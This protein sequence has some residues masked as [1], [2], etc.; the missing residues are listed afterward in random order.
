[1]CENCTKQRSQ[2]FTE[3]RDLLNYKRPVKGPLSERIE[4]IASEIEN[5]VTEDE[6]AARID[7]CRAEMIL[8]RCVGILRS[9]PGTQFHG[10][11]PAQIF[12]AQLERAIA[13]NPL[14]ELFAA[15][16]GNAIVIELPD[17]DN[18]D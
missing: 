17:D 7:A 2:A 3:I 4:A 5:S 9:C 10:W 8:A 14:A 13:A 12:Q 15:M 11:S 18:D 1:M 6:L 16:M